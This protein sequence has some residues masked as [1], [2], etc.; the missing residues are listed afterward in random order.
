ME[1]SEVGMLFLQ[2]M[3]G[4][5]VYVR[6]PL[7]L[8]SAIIYGK[9]RDRK[10]EK[11]AVKAIKRAVASQKAIDTADAKEVDSL[12]KYI[13]DVLKPVYHRMYNTMEDFVYTEDGGA[14][15]DILIIRAESQNPKN[16]KEFGQEH[17]ASTKDVLFEVVKPFFASMAVKHKI[18]TSSHITNTTEEIA[19]D[20]L[21]MIRASVHIR[22]GSNTETKALEDKVFTFEC[23]VDVWHNIT[24]ESVLLREKRNQE[25]AKI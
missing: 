22:A 7:L 6:Y 16:V 23:M 13:E 5:P 20:A 14:W 3:E 8:T 21:D 4:L 18:A 1:F 9:Y 11:N 10:H 15:R 12:N 2:T 25:V 24:K 17:R 19:K